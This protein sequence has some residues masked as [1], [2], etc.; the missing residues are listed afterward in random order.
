MW[1]LV[2]LV[3]R[4]VEL[5]RRLFVPV[6]EQEPSEV[7]RQELA[8][9]EPHSEVALNLLGLLLYEGVPLQGLEPPPETRGSPLERSLLWLVS[10]VHC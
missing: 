3:G 8:E 7:D 6:R 1:L 9:L 5:V 4:L 2:E 10:A